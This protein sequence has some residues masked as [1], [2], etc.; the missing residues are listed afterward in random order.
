[1]VACK[2]WCGHQSVSEVKSAALYN[3]PTVINGQVLPTDKLTI[4]QKTVTPVLNTNVTNYQYKYHKVLLLSDNQERGC[5]E[6]IKNKLP[7]NFEV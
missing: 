4:K 5:A 6:R 2:K 1:V 3:I 7:S